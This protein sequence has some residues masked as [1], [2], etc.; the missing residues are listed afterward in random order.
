MASPSESLSSSLSPS[1]SP[2]L[3]SPARMLEA[4]LI[5]VEFPDDRKE[6]FEGTLEDYNISIPEKYLTPMIETGFIDQFVRLIMKIEKKEKKLIKNS[7]DATKREHEEKNEGLIDEPQ[8]KKQKRNN[9][10][11]S[12]ETKTIALESLNSNNQQIKSEN[13]DYISSTS[14]ALD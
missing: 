9:E 14:D 13:E 12:M 4:A 6:Y 3:L 11:D 7:H 10:L 8:N 2:V 1:A 5:D